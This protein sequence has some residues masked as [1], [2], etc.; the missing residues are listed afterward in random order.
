[1][2]EWF[3]AQDLAGLSGLPRTARRVRSMASREAWKSRKRAGRGG[4]F[5]YHI[6]SLPQESQAALAIREHRKSPAG[7]GMASAGGSGHP[8]QADGRLNSTASG[9][10]AGSSQGA[11]APTYSSEALWSRFDG[12]PDRHKQQARER[13]A[14]IDAA[15]RLI[16]AGTPAR[17]AW[18]VVAEGAGVSR[19]TVQR[20]HQR[21]RG[22]D[23]A[24]W[25]AALAS[26]YVGRVAKA[27]FDDRA[28]DYVRADYLRLEAPT[29]TACYERLKLAAAEHGW[30]IPS[31]R[32]VERRLD[33]IPP[34]VQVYARQGEAALMAMYP[35]MQRTV[36]DLRALEWINGD[37]Y[38]HNVFVKWPDGTIARPKT[39]FWQDV[40]SRKFL[41]WRTD[42][43]E[44]TD[45]IRL[46]FGDLI[47]RFGIPSHVTIDN[48]RA[49]ANKWMTGRVA[50]RYRFKVRDDDPLGLI[51]A[52]CGPDSVHWTSVHNGRGHGQAKP[53]ERQFGVGGL[54]EYVD[55]HPSF[56]G[57]YTGPDPTAKPEN[58]ASRAVPLDVFLRVMGDTLRAFNAR[59]GRRSEMAG[60]SLSYDQVFERS[61]A[62]ATIRKAT[63]EQ[64][65]MLM[66]TAEARTVAPDGSIT[67]DAGSAT[68]VG[69][70]R[71]ACEALYTHIGAKVIAR[72]D[73][74]ALH[75][76]VHVY[77]LDNRYL[78]QADCVLAAG[79]GD[80]EAGR[81][82]NRA[83]KQW[84]K[85][86]RAMAESEIRMSAEEAAQM[87][88]EIEDAEVPD[89]KVVEGLFQRAVG[90]SFEP[91]AGDEEYQE[92]FSRAVSRIP[93]PGA[94][95]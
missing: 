76:A 48:T 53:V 49:A 30:R 32:T 65:R 44:H 23:R 86:Q 82:H 35:A 89:S 15:L 10:A 63:I 68:G 25:L 38:Q 69:K 52:I 33:R 42:Q 21:C 73:P 14:F 80:S 2:R 5:E 41:A 7:A 77:T 26:R 4:G 28:W 8:D 39:W 47:R 17:Q 87:L 11:A 29:A 50:N 27:E 51:P 62:A 88:P 75:E 60:G 56:A 45:V 40:Y 84:I 67:L 3:A 19:G 83:R 74:A 36:K 55:K 13:L 18:S 92:K 61:Y 79:F 46:S 58:Y 90:Q 94:D 1:M 95:Q 93:I 6:S 22:I 59:P 31:Q 91:D 34:A 54:G 9:A 24:D 64:Q 20:W 12:L 72:F 70:N 71:Y 85:A 81:R 57:A 37:G 43:T 66:L 16:A 78:G